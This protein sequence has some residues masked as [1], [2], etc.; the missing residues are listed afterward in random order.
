MKAE[1]NSLCFY[2]KEKISV[3]QLTR[4]NY[5]STENM[6][7]NK[8]GVE[9]ASS[10]PPAARTQRYQKNDVLVS[11]IRP[12]FKKIW[13]ADRDGG[14]SNDVLVL[15]AKEGC[16]PGFLYYLLAD[17]AFF[18]YA[19]VTARGTKM[20]RGDKAAIM[21]YEVPAVS[22][23]GQARIADILSPLDQKIKWNRRIIDNLQQQAAAIFKCWFLDFSPFG[24]KPPAGWKETELDALTT[25]IGRG[26]TPQYVDSS[27]Q[28]VINQKCIRNHGL[29]LSFAR[30]HRPKSVNEKWL[31]FGDL[32]INSTGTGTLGRAAQVW[33]S[34]HNL[35]ADSHITIVRPASPELMFYIGLWAMLHETKI[36]ALHTGTTGQT[37]LPRDRVK[38]LRLLRPDTETLKRFH[39]LLAP[40]IA[41]IAANQSESQALARVRD[42]LIPKLLTGETGV[43]HIRL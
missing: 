16:H 14:C 38:A 5:V 34:P 11:N 24:G 13:L 40:L 12:Y 17:D 3:A 26:I 32:L 41:A 1:L 10:L 23:A 15:R 8:G 2:A 36:E 21:Q 6:R 33:F 27:N 29:D 37:E 9:A 25:F 35:T 18:D 4:F 7:L 39:D 43:S 22:K 42:A 31:Q 19:T 28:T 30:N 20:P